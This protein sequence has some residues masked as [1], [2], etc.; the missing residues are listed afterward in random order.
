MSA[1]Y[2][3]CASYTNDN[4]S[5]IKQTYEETENTNNI[6]RE[7]TAFSMYSEIFYRLK[8]SNVNCLIQFSPFW[9]HDWSWIIKN[10]K[11]KQGPLLLTWFEFNQSIN[12]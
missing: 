6:Y 4:E 2:H 12:K 7:N 8:F 9:Y 3:H 5:G 1:N 11:A 10:R